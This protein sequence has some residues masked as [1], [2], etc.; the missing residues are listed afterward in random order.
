MVDLTNNIV[1]AVK[2]GRLLNTQDFIQALSYPSTVTIFTGDGTTKP[3][4]EMTE[5]D[6]IQHYYQ[7]GFPYYYYYVTH[8]DGIYT[9]GARLKQ[10]FLP[11]SWYEIFSPSPKATILFYV[12]LFFI[13][14][15]VILGSLIL[16]KRYY[17]RR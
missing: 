1:L 4:S 2:E 10:Y 5:L 17:D 9:M 16:V 12:K 6:Q 3:L 11:D 8:P 7:A 13:A 15:W 14:S